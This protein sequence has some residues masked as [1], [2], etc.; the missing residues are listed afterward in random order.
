MVDGAKTKPAPDTAI[1]IMETLGISKNDS[2]FIGD[3]NIDIN[4]AKNAGI[5]SIGVLW[6]F[7]GLN[8][9]KDAGADYIVSKPSEIFDIV[10]AD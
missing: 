10:A 1:R 5:E 7:R 4:T 2:V 3:T 6:G 8:E 9:L